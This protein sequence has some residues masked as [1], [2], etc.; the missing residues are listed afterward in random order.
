MMSFLLCPNSTRLFYQIPVSQEEEVLGRIEASLEDPLGLEHA[1]HALYDMYP[2]RRGN[3]FADEVYRL[4][5]APDATQPDFPVTSKISNNDVILLTVQP[6]GSGD[7]FDPK[8]LPLVSG[9]SAVSAEARVIATGPTYVDIVM[10]T[11]T[12]EANFG[13]APNNEGPSG[14][15][16]PRLRLRVD[17][18]F[19]EIPYKRM[20]EALT[21][22]STIPQRTVESK[23][24]DE[25]GENEVT[26]TNM[27]SR[28][29]KENNSSNE[30]N[31]NPHNNI[32]MDEVLRE[33]IIATHAFSDPSTPMFH[34]VDACDLQTLSRQ[35]EKPPMSSS[36]RL[37]NQVLTYVQ[38]NK[39]VFNALNGPQLAA[40]GA[41]LTRKL[42]L[43]QGPPGTG[44]V[45]SHQDG[46]LVLLCFC[47]CISN[48]STPPPGLSTDVNC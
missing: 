13:P 25:I 22:M 26:N 44:K 34:D 20:V 2:E 32:C 33:A 31:G 15:G 12:F 17:R 36:V 30:G 35:L 37:A 6:M 21:I 42:T 40:I 45:I 19:S 3:L 38:A 46:L 9:G 14:K 7:F 18:F 23:I 11:G 29:N 5:K 27:N 16:D 47:A 1:G 4:I 48:F 39:H 41:A 28:S 24:L 10:P 8:N 43:I